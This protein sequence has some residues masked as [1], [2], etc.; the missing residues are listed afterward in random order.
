MFAGR[1]RRVNVKRIGRVGLAQARDAD[2]SGR[3]HAISLTLQTPAGGRYDAQPYLDWHCRTVPGDI[4]CGCSLHAQAGNYPEK[5][6]TMIS[7]AA[8]GSTPDMDARFIADGDDQAVE[9]AGRRRQ[10]CGRLW[11]Y[12]RA[13]RG[14]RRARRLHPVHAVARIVYRAA[15]HRAE[16]CR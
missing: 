11:Q 15:G 3:R 13:C 16:S 9:A 12:C 14:G 10:S 2:G 4:A 1:L 7:D 6:V 8:A 5:P